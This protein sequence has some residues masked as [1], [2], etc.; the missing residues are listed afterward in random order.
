MKPSSRPGQVEETGRRMLILSQQ[1]LYLDSM[2]NFRLKVFRAVAKHLSF[3]KAAEE[4]YLS[5]PVRWRI[6]TKRGAMCTLLSC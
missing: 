6:R 3:R 1:N 2:L 5:Q 4:L